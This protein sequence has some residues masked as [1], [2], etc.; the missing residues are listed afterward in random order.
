MAQGDPV[1]LQWSGELT[2]ARMGELKLALLEALGRASKVELD[3]RGATDADAP[4]LQL[5][6]AAHREALSEG[7][8]LELAGD[9]PVLARCAESA[10]FLRRE[11]CV[12]GCLWSFAEETG[13]ESAA[14]R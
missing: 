1:V 5:V 11:G 9:S 6:C 13:A 4:F 3:V 12:P 8:T 7:K 2:L 10:G 14:G